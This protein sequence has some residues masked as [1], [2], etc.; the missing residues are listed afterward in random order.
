MIFVAI[1]LALTLCNNNK[2]INNNISEQKQIA[3]KN[4]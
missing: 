1:M 2:T 4:T 3:E